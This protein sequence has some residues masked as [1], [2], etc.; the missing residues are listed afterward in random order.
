MT[1]VVLSE[2]HGKVGLISINR[3]EALNALNNQVL[4]ELLAAFAA[5]DADD[6]QR[7]AVLT[8][9]EKAFAAGADT[10]EMAPQGR[11]INPADRRRPRRAAWS[12]C[13]ARP[14]PWAFAT[15]R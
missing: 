8:G 12:R 6:G 7:C 14:R 13:A 5:F 10:K 1:Q 15:G 9:S 2:T 4:G 11:W 3:P